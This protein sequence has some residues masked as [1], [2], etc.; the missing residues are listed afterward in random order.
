MPLER[1]EHFLVI[2][3]DL[4]ATK[5]FYC[6]ILGL[7]DGFRPELSFEGL[8][9]YLGD[10]PCIHVAERETYAV[11]TTERDLPMST[12]FDGTGRLDHVAFNATGYDEIVAKLAAQRLTYKINRLDDIGLRQIFVA[13]PNGLSIELNFR[14]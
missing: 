6:D 5:R 3:D 10:V 1:M 8:W 13:D 7:R 14:S 11:Y 2:T 12:P 4:E 9:L